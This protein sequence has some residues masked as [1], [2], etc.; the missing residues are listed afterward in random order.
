MIRCKII[1]W[2]LIKISVQI[3]Y[4]HT[5]KSKGENDKSGDIKKKPASVRR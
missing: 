4:K 1:Y 5:I 2:I 3:S